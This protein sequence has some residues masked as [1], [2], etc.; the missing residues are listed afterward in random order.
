MPNDGD[1]VKLHN[2]QEMQYLKN[3]ERPTCEPHSVEDAKYE[4]DDGREAEFPQMGHG[5]VRYS[6]K[7]ND[8]QQ[9]PLVAQSFV[10][11]MIEVGTSENGEYG[12][13]PQGDGHGKF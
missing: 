8:I 9:W 2:S 5:F 4:I 1:R 6:V 13:P 11:D 3:S 12:I 7:W 10:R